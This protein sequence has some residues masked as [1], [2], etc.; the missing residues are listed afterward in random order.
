MAKN[1]T[2]RSDKE[3]RE[4]LDR[5]VDHGGAD[6]RS[7]ALQ[8]TSRAELA[9]RGYLDGTRLDTPLRQL[10]REF[11]RLFI[12][13][14]FAWLGVSVLW[15]VELRLSGIF[16]LFMGWLMFALDRGLARV[17]PSIT[18]KL[19]GLVSRAESA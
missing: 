13:G 14:G 6:N 16:L 17:E 10:V 11:S 12:Y 2:A 1:V 15:S 7:D 4:A 5:F 8:Q 19:S 18:T 9:R 3:H